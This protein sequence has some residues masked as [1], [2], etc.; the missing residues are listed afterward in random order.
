M[1]TAEI[2]EQLILLKQSRII[3]ETDGR[4]ELIHDSLAEIIHNERSDEEIKRIEAA[5]IVRDAYQTNLTLTNEHKQGARQEPKR[6]LSPAELHFINF[7]E[8]HRLEISEVER[9]Y[10]KESRTHYQKIEER[11]KEIDAAW[12]E[13][14]SQNTVEAYQSFERDYPDAPAASLSQIPTKKQI[15]QEKELTRSIRIAWR[16]ALS[17]NTIDAYED[18]LGRFPNNEFTDEAQKKKRALR[19]AQERKE[20]AVVLSGFI[21]LILILGALAL[22]YYKTQNAELIGQKEKITKQKREL[23]K[24]QDQMKEQDSLLRVSNERLR[25]D[26]VKLAEQTKMLV[27]DS[28]T[29]NDRN[30]ILTG[31]VRKLTLNE[32]ELQKTNKALDDTIKVLDFAK[33]VSEQ[34]SQELDRL[35]LELKTNQ[36]LK[37][38]QNKALISLDSKDARIKTTEA[39]KAYILNQENRGKADDANVHKSLIRAYEMQR[40]PSNQNYLNQHEE[41]II[42]IIPLTDQRFLAIGRD[43]K[44][45]AFRYK[46]SPTFLDVYTVD[47][48]SYGQISFYDA[49]ARGNALLMATDEGL[50][51]GNIVGRNLENLERCV[52]SSSDDA[53]TEIIRQKIIQVG[54]VEEES[55]RCYFVTADHKLCY[56]QL[57]GNQLKILDITKSREEA[58]LICF[59]RQKRQNN[60]TY[61]SF[62]LPERRGQA[63]HLVELLFENDE[64]GLGKFI[65]PKTREKLASVYSFSSSDINMIEDINFIQTSGNH[66]A[67]GTKQ[68]QIFLLHHQ[69]GEYTLYK[70]YEHSAPIVDIN[71]AADSQNPE[72]Y[73]FLATASQ[74]GV[75]N[76][77]TFDMIREKR[78]PI[79]LQGKQRS[80]ETA[81]RTYSLSF[82]RNAQGKTEVLF[83]GC[84]DGKVKEYVVDIDLLASLLAQTI[85]P[86]EE[87]DLSEN[88][89]N[90]DFDREE[91]ALKDLCA[92]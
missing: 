20:R 79:N 65:R 52:L 70:L 62:L 69:G 77:Y 44:L 66:I 48:E 72:N 37:I 25:Q 41:A 4:I 46:E 36:K 82:G 13:A 1:T 64:N 58:E 85:C 90:I 92:Q 28:I 22:L 9:A 56:A 3:K 61:E 5:R 60:K 12:M 78:K 74:D 34:K 24:N 2:R 8:D 19:K 26:S 16:E 81:I 87:T 18:F 91:K 38:A 7:C 86:L 15:L 73:A 35:N 40:H 31:L 6:R 33:N 55:D 75:V 63:T 71:F 88:D 11:K 23:E 10:L 17:E 51:T 53:D 29:I 27:R 67:L 89:P 39:L 84:E 76:L 49:S 21:F 43:S 54:F 59:F 14:V 80:E 30:R 42:K 50:F 45:V 83:V 32:E 68:G 47:K 57:L